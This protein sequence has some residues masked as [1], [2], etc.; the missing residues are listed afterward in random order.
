MKLKWI[1]IVLIVLIGC[2]SCSQ[3]EDN[4]GKD[5]YLWESYQIANTSSGERTLY[6]YSQG[7]P[8]IVY[9]EIYNQSKPVFVTQENAVKPL[10]TLLEVTKVTLKPEQTVVFYEQTLPEDKFA[11]PEARC[12]VHCGYGSSFY[13]SYR[14]RAAANLIGDSV[15]IFRE[16]QDS[17]I[18]MANHEIWETWYDNKNFI[19]HHICQITK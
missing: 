10:S 18:S 3:V 17:I 4:M 15:Q 6:F 1:L 7:A 2:S 11:T 19:Y 5:Y 9:A 12:L 14:Y 13:N 8:K 16:G